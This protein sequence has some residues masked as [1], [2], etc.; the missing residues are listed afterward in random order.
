[1]RDHSGQ[2]AFP[3]GK[4]DEGETALPTPCVKPGRRS[5]LRRAIEPLGWLDP[6]LTG[7]GYR[8]MPLVA[9]VDPS[10]TLTINPH[11]VEDVF[12]TTPELSDG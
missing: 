7:T 11:E 10:F 8:I 5:G 1:M 4:I 9:I 6:Y 3:G 12:E 2:F